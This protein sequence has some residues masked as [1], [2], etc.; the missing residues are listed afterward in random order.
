MPEHRQQN[1]ILMKKSQVSLI[2]IP[3]TL[4]LMTSFILSILL[5]AVLCASDSIFYLT[6]VLKI[7]CSVSEDCHEISRTFDQ[8]DWL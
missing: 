3:F 6:L 1:A 7:V 5:L 8:S 2:Y 4:L